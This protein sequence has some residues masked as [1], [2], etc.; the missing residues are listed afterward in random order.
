MTQFVSLSTIRPVLTVG[1]ALSPSPIV[2][3][4]LSACALCTVGVRA[5]YCRRARSVLSACRA[6][7][8]DKWGCLSYF[9]C[10]LRSHRSS[11]TVTSAQNNRNIRLE[12]FS[13]KIVRFA[14]YAAAAVTA[15]AAASAVQLLLP[16][17][18]THDYVDNILF[19]V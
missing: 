18:T 7:A 12:F 4:E 8:R 6:I 14:V 2:L 13:Y 19:Y 15:A 5:L 11:F 3:A 1:P 10:S 17:N 16:T 9:H